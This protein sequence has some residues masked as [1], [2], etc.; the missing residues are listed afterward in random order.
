M[1]DEAPAAL[2]QSQEAP[3]LL[4]S[5]LEAASAVATLQPQ[6]CLGLGLQ[7]QRFWGSSSSSSSSNKWWAK[8][9]IAD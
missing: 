2:S 1:V 6:A 5:N 8:L 7:R 4:L 9:P 3:S